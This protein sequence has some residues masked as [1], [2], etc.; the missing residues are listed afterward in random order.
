MGYK[1]RPVLPPRL[2]SWVIMGGARI[3]GHPKLHSKF[4]VSL[5][6]SRPYLNADT[7]EK[8]KKTEGKREKG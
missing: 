1:T 3:Q 2:E 5:G 4:E 7:R 8:K 6:Y